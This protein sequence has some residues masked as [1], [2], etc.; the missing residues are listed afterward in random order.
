VFLIAAASAA[1]ACA[2]EERKAS[3]DTAKGNTPSGVAGHPVARGDSPATSPGTAT[4]K[5]FFIAIEGATASDKVGCGDGVLPV[6]VDAQGT[7]APLRFAMDQLLSGQA[8]PAG[9]NAYHALS[10]MKLK[11]DS[12]AM[13]ADTAI[14]GLSGRVSY[15]GVCDAPRIEA[16]LTRTATQFATVRAARF[17]VN[18]RP[19]S[20]LL[21]EQ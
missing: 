20:E 18:G 9:A 15:G 12:I 4:V 21:S 1:L 5:L 6:T 10:Q 17:F 11:I 16:Q 19:L 2:T 7:K 13:R 14:I 8:K 3:A